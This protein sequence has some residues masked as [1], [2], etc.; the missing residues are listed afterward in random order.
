MIVETKTRY[1]TFIKGHSS[2]IKQVS[3]LYSLKIRWEWS[4]LRHHKIVRLAIVTRI[5]IRI[6]LIRVN[7][8]NSK[9][10]KKIELLY[11]WITFALKCHLNVFYMCLITEDTTS[12]L[13]RTAC[14]KNSFLFILLSWHNHG[15]NDIN[16]LN[17]PC[18]LS[19][20]EI[21]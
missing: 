16:F 8:F 1:W 19:V 2:F 9:N 11:Q 21:Y 3:K 4:S 20:E 10:N 17:F 13:S 15:Q 5:R 6:G 7:C 14:I 18:T 12:N